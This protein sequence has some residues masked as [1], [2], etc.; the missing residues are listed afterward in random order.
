M[1]QAVT[2]APSTAEPSKTVFIVI[3]VRPV[4]ELMSTYA[5]YF[6]EFE[7]DPDW[8]ISTA[9]ERVVD[10]F[11]SQELDALSELE[12][13]AEHHEFT[14]LQAMVDQ[15]VACISQ[16]LPE[17]LT[18]ADLKRLGYMFYGREKAFFFL[19]SDYEYE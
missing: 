3:N 6:N 10:T 19:T 15:A 11:S 13:V 18:E 12:S 8:I 16:S 14:T 5:K 7:L 2:R 1:A 9:L 17:N 4:C